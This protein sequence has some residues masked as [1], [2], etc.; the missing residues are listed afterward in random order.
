MSAYLTYGRNTR[1]RL[2]WSP[3][4]DHADT[5]AICGIHRLGK[6]PAAAAREIVR[7]VER[8]LAERR[9]GVGRGHAPPA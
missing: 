7:A 6:A 9:S 5:T 4:L 2:R 8:M 3:D 1:G